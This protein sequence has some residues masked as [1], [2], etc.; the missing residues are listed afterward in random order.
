MP[1]SHKKFVKFQVPSGF[2]VDVANSQHS[3]GQE[4]APKALAFTANRALIRTIQGPWKKQVI[5][6]SAQARLDTFKASSLKGLVDRKLLFLV[7][8]EAIG[9]NVGYFFFLQSVIEQLAPARIAVSN[10]GAASDIY[11]LDPRIE[12]FPLWITS[13]QIRSFDRVIDLLDV[14]ALRELAV[15]PCDPET[16]L[17]AYTGMPPTNL[18]ATESES[19]GKPKQISIFPLASSPMRSLPIELCRYLVRKISEAGIKVTIF[20]NGKQ[21]QSV[22]YAQSLQSLA[23]ERVVLHPGCGSLGELLSVIADTDYSVFCDSGPAHLSKLFATRGIAIHTS[24]EAGPLRGRFNNLQ[25]WQSKFVGKHC[26]APCGLAGPWVDGQG[27]IG[28]MGSLDLPR[29]ELLKRAVL[30]DDQTNQSMI[31]DP[32][33]CVDDLNKSREQIW[34]AIQSSWSSQDVQKGSL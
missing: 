33:P 10:T 13:E 18:Y 6:K 15:K 8:G 9:D 22:V 11:H 34:E 28:C 20:L 1:K 12:V 29:Q 23:G 26:A 16:A 27:R 17:V 30:I 21:R 2:R 32:I 19:S 25:T 4:L 31:A 14:P 7:P 5:V 24:A 3:P